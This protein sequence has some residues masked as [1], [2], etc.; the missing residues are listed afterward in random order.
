MAIPD[1][2]DR[3]EEIAPA[4][5]RAPL[6]TSTE[7]PEFAQKAR[8]LQALR[9]AVVDA[10]TVSGGLWLSYLFVFFYLAIAAS[11]VTHADLFFE[12]AVK[13]PFLNVDLPLL[14]FFVLGPLL[15]LIVHAYT[16]LHFSFLAGKVGAF[17]DELERQIERGDASTGERLRRQL[18]SNIFVQF[19]A[20]PSEIRNG[21][22]GFLLRAIAWIS[23][24]I[25]PVLLLVLFQLQFLAYQSEWISWWQRLVIVADLALLWYVWPQVARLAGAFLKKGHVLPGT[26]WVCLFA[27]AS[28]LPILLVFTV[29][30]FPGEWLD[31]SL[32][33]LPL[34]PSWASPHALLVG[35]EA[36]EVTKRPRTPWSNR[37]ILPGISAIDHARSDAG[38]R[39][40][41]SP[42][43]V[44]LRGRHLEA[45]VLDGAHLRNIDFT[46]A[47][48]KAAVLDFAD[49]R[50]TK[51]QCASTAY[52]EGGMDFLDRILAE[53]QQQCADL[54]RA[55]LY[56]AQ[57]QGAV[58]DGSQL[59]GASL[60]SAQ[61]Q[62][63][64]LGEARLQGAV[65]D[66]AQLEGAFL[67]D[68]R[69]QGASLDSARLQAAN[70][71]YAQLQGALLDSAQLQGASLSYAQLQGASLK[72]TKLQ[73]ASLDSVFVWRAAPPQD[74]GAEGARII[75]LLTGS[76]YQGYCPKY[77]YCKWTAEAVANLERIIGTDTPPG[78]HGEETKAAALARI[79][80]LDPG[81]TSEWQADTWTR[82]EKPMPQP[83][84]YEEAYEKHLAA[85]LQQ[86]GCAAEGPY[87][88]SGFLLG[89]SLENRFAA[90]PA[91]AARIANA[92][93]DAPNCTGARG[94]SEPDKASL[95]KT[96]RDRTAMATP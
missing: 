72:N 54:R 80:L 65:L 20:G 73:D 39:I 94:L 70:L 21:L 85:R 18:P 27:L 56:Y 35:G 10:A 53:E 12:H 95:R 82:L 3:V 22:M 47:D 86:L 50:E 93:L 40:V 42:E 37:L 63:A 24:V 55:S 91:L 57:L 31:E 32:P 78:P 13:L 76:I 34:V 89:G 8:D 7:L 92:F 30:T 6:A 87:V 44:T 68:G 79:A 71:G 5:D 19:L 33:T 96:I 45:A 2:I 77:D 16:L 15:F 17:D 75:Q 61:L 74:A 26:V 38:E 64:S 69:L 48:L 62:G 46:G 60:D 59:Q 9:D 84:D 29:A 58:L 36:N 25:G 1:T 43:M 88:I 67:Y 49:L 23:L 52:S 90:D 81:N 83:A 14:G 51:F 41:A 4:P 28:L 11:G 66:N